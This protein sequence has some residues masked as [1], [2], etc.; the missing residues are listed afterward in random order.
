MTI[1]KVQNFSHTERPG[2]GE[3][4][5]PYILGLLVWKKAFRF[6]FIQVS[7][8]FPSN[9]IEISMKFHSELAGQ[10]GWYHH[11]SIAW[12]LDRGGH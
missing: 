2:S 3:V 10:A 11:N 4:S 12:R 6:I 5:D 9:F 7:F 8:K 1:L